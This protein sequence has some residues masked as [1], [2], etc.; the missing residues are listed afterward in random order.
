M[1]VQKA[2]MPEPVYALVGSDSFLQMQ[3]LT[4]LLST[5]PKDVQRL[6]FDGDR[7]DL[8]D[9]LDELR[10]YAMFGGS[11]LVVIRSAE[12]FISRYREQL[13]DYLAHPSESGTLVLR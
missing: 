11:K 1:G 7:A 8:P 3:R 6:E 2:A 13:E 4:E 10:S 12:E 5:L 9:V